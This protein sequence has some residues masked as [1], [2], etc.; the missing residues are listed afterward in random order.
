MDLAFFRR[1]DDGFEPTPMACSMWADDQMHGVAAS[2]LIARGLE[3][4]IEALDRGA[5]LVPARYHVDLF[6]PPKMVPTRIRT[7]VVRNGPRIALLDAEMVQSSADG[8]ERVVARAT[9]TYLRAGENPAGEVWSASERATPPPLDL[10]PPTSE[11]HVPFFTSES[12]WSDDFGKHQNA[13]RHITWQV[14]VPTVAGEPMTPFQ[15][16]A[17]IAD[18][19]SMVTNWGSNGVEWINTDISLALARRPAGMEVG[20]ATID[21]VAHEGISVGTAEVFDREGT[22]GTATVTA[23][24]NSKRTVD[25]TAPVEGGPATSV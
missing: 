24:A 11:P 12:P 4:Q 20:L 9:C 21:H 17:S 22:I 23:L 25:F 18:A 5:E 10:A 2:G 13:G 6:R 3:D 1:T 7:S 14:G 15:T 16:V 19:T 8:E